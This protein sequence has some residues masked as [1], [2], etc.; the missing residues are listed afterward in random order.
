MDVSGHGHLR[1]LAPVIMIR[2]GEYEYVQMETARDSTSSRKS[3]EMRE[4]SR[5]EV[6][7]KVVTQQESTWT[8]G[9]GSRPVL[10]NGGAQATKAPSGAGLLA[11]GDCGGRQ[12][13]KGCLRG[14]SCSSASSR[15][16]SA[17][18]CERSRAKMAWKAGGRGETRFQPRLLKA[19]ICSVGTG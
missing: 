2:E 1:A 16:Q 8:E 3:V 12:P 9:A 7:Q 17:T 18:Y 4:E 5:N 11:A 13:L 14:A 10:V 6:A 19:T 15:W